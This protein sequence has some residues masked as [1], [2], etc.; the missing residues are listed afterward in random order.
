MNHIFTEGG[1]VDTLQYSFYKEQGLNSAAQYLYSSGNHLPTELEFA[2]IIWPAAGASSSARELA[3][4]V[5]TLQQGKY[6]DLEHLESL[7]SP[8][9][10]N[11][12]GT[13]GFSELENGY[14]SGWQVISRQEHPAVSASGGDHSTIIIYPDEDLSI[15]VVTNLYGSLPIQF[16]DEV[17]QYYR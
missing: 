8:Y 17:A 4:Y 12:G 15:I 5:I 1:M 10:L 7:W 3:Q 11:N 14:A 16:V 6:F 9:R 2:K 13:E